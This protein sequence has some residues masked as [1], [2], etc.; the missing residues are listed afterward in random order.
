MHSVVTEGV[1]AGVVAGALVGAFIV[2]VLFGGG[3]YEYHERKI[4][5]QAFDFVDLL[6]DM[7][8]KG[9]IETKQFRRGKKSTN[10]FAV[11][12]AGVADDTHIPREV[13]RSHITLLTKLGNGAFGEV[14]K[15]FLDESSSGGVPGYMV[16]VK[17]CLVSGGEGEEDMV[18]EAAIMAQV[19]SHPNVVPL[20][21]V[22]T[23]GLYGDR[24]FYLL[25]RDSS[26]C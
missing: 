3:T 25:K 8:S 9:E 21:G 13:K 26:W 19:P 2:L 22:V 17:T 16:A 12:S 1:D 7:H 20:I 14:W 11:A 18:K 23:R 4:K 24:F 5:M 10:S 6:S 15:S